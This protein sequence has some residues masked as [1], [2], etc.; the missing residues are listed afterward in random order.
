MKRKLLYDTGLLLFLA[1]A[2]AAIWLAGRRVRL[3]YADEME[4]AAK[5]HSLVVEAVRE[6]RL[7]RGY[8]IA[9]GDRL[10]LGLIGA[11]SSA[12]TTSLGS[13]EA[14]RTSQL[15]EMAALMVRLFHEA[16][17]REG[18]R[19]GACF[20]ASFPGADL[21]VLCAAEVMGLKIV[22]SAAVG[23]STYG[24]NLPGYV[25]PEMILTAVNAGLLS[26]MPQSVSLGGEGDAGLNMFG[27]L[28]EETEEIEAMKKRLAEE[29]FELLYVADFEENVR[30]RMEQMGG[31]EAFVNVG[32]NVLGIGN[33]DAA[34]S[35]GQGLLKAAHP[36]LNAKSGLVERYLNLDVPVI[37]IL[38]LKQLCAETGVPF[39]PLSLPESGTA[40]VYYSRNYSKPAIAMTALAA[41]AAAL[42]IGRDAK[43]RKGTEN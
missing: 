29:G 12:I 37:H 15:P 43:K 21:A 7:A 8:E 13:L 14:K 35:F 34:L 9:E 3:P 31:I 36:S 40:E 23:A 17:L 28:M 5:L 41:F 1:A 39:D 42:L 20:S 16:G 24:A 30:F 4:E 22:Y 33:S 10:Q 26:T 2:A 18:D 38:N 19:V 32:G 25:L 11:E 6:E 27:V